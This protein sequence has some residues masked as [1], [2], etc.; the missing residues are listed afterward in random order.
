[1]I[2]AL[3]LLYAAPF[4]GR[5][6]FGSTGAARLD[7]LQPE[8]RE[9]EHAI[10]AARFAD[11]LRIALDLQ[12]AYPQEPLVAYWLASI[13]HGLDRP[14]DEAAAW[15]TY[16]KRS[17]A[18]EEA[19]PAIGQ[20][21]ERLGDRTRALHEYERCAELDPRQPDRLVDLGE[22]AER[23]GEPS[24]ALAAFTR[25]AQIDPTDPGV[26]DRVR[27]LSLKAGGS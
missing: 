10:A 6:G 18:P 17:T 22:A 4:L 11:A 13:Y 25:A 15:E 8:A 3:L 19:C 23:L 14:G 16:M 2:G 21:Y 5:N 1:L 7:A 12:K 26:A 27:Q 24:V 20:L 9:V